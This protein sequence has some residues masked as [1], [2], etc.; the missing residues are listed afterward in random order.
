VCDYYR[1]ED[2]T[3]SVISA[4]IAGGFRVYF[5]RKKTLAA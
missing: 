2:Q 1:N 5:E 3:Y 4:M